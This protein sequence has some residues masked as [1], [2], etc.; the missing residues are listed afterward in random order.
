MYLLTVTCYKVWF[1]YNIVCGVH[2]YACD[3]ISCAVELP[4]SVTACMCIARVCGCVQHSIPWL[5]ACRT[6]QMTVVSAQT[7]AHQT[8]STAME[9][10]IITLQR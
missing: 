9:G 8:T 2:K 10:T 3:V 6:A 5:S 4:Q 1:T 7:L